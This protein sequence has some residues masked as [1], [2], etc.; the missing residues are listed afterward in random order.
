MGCEI[1]A[2]ISTH[3]IHICVSDNINYSLQTFRQA[4]LPLLRQAY[5]PVTYRNT[6]HEPGIIFSFENNSTAISAAHTL[7]SHIDRNGIPVDVR[8]SGRT[9]I[10]TP[11]GV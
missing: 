4:I 10:C 6:S 7:Q 1:L 5:G 11:E 2:G 9:V 3:D 8:P